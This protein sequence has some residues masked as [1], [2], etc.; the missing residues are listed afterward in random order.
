MLSLRANATK[1]QAEMD[2]QRGTLSVPSLCSLSPSLSGETESGT[3]H[4]EGL[5][6]RTDLGDIFFSLHPGYFQLLARLINNLAAIC[7]TRLCSS[8]SGDH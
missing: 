3:K 6:K 8:S 1:L 5:H 2:F 7:N 4:G